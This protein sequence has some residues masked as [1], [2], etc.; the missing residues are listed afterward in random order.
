MDRIGVGYCEIDMNYN[1]R[2]PISFMVTNP[3]SPTI[4]F[5]SGDND[6]RFCK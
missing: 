4:S 6:F 2:T 3:L 1:Y 5:S